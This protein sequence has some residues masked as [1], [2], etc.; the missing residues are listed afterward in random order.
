M[1]INACQ[2]TSKRLIKISNGREVIVYRCKIGVNAGVD[3]NCYIMG[4]KT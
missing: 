2:T 3:V 4:P 1:K